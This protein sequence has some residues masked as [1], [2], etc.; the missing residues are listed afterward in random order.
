MELHTQAEVALTAA[1]AEQEAAVRGE[2]MRAMLQAARQTRAEEA[3][4]LLTMLTL[5]VREVQEL[6]S[7]NTQIQIQLQL[8]L[9]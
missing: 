4:V 3:V 5:V 1:L 2:A 6:F 9:V 8:V 7:L